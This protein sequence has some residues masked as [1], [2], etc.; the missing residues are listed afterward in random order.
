MIPFSYVGPEDRFDHWHEVTC[1]NFSHTE[2]RA[3]PD[4]CF[5]A[6]VDAQPFDSLVFSDIS[7]RIGGGK[8]LSLQREPAHIRKDGH[9]EFFLWIGREGAT[10]FEQQGRAV[11]LGPG[12]I[13]LMD[14]TKPFRLEFCGVSTTSLIIAERSFVDKQ[15]AVD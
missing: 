12:E 11:T 6:T 4:D 2:C 10:M 8:K 3:I 5:T 9:E 13:M 1:R 7:S 14:Q 15:A